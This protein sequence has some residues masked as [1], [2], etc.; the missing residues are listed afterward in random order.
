MQ[1]PEMADLIFDM[2]GRTLSGTDFRL[3]KS[4][5]A[6]V[7]KI[8]GGKQMLGLPLWDYNP[9]FEFSLNIG[10]RLDAVEAV[11]HQFS[12]S[13]PKYQSL[14]FT[15]MTRL[16]HF[17]G[18]PP[19]YRV[20]TAGD[21]ACFESVLSVVIQDKIIPFFNEHQDVQALDGAVN[22]QQPGIDITQNPPGAMHAA[23]CSAWRATTILSVSS[24]SI[25]PKCNL[26]TKRTILS[27]ASLNTSRHAEIARR[28]TSHC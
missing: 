24:P 23:C 11:F 19:R 28:F 9:V 1:K 22:C 7:R 12:R 5:D 26:L 27:T 14:S 18:G 16:E 6:F 17:T 15:A 21:V 13:P 3:K 2:L 8:P 4:E 20:T 10:I 25:G